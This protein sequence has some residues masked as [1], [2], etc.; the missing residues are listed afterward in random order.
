[1]NK[2]VL[3]A[4]AML[5]PGIAM[6]DEWRDW[7]LGERLK[8]SAGVFL[9]DIDTTAAVTQKS[10]FVSGDLIDF[11]AD[12]G[13]EDD[14]SA[15]FMALDWRFFKRHSLN[16]N[17]YSLDRDAVA[18]TPRNLTFD[19]VTFPSGTEVDTTVDVTVYEL[20]Y[21]YSILFDESKDLYVGLGISAQDLDFSIF[22]TQFPSLTVTESFVAPLPTVN[23][24]FDYVLRDDWVLSLKAGYMDVDAT[25]SDDDFDAKIVAL[26]AGVRWKPVENF[27]VGL[28]YTSFSVDGQFED[29]DIIAELDLEYKGPR[30]SFD[31]FF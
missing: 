5:L 27:G 28:Y 14:K 13:L 11:E 25:F 17:Y 23:A 4:A 12:L 22:A 7:P 6:A 24:G 15:G 8:L 21:S 26:D 9:S 16:L 19:G 3:M 30:L 20:A 29:D 1:M 18:T 31:L 10:P 2:G